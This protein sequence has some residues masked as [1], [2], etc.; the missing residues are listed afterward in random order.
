MRDG[1]R[2]HWNRRTTRLGTR[3]VVAIGIV[4]EIVMERSGMEIGTDSPGRRHRH[5][6]L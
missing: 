3:R 2:T 4:V 5:N 1:E 6:V